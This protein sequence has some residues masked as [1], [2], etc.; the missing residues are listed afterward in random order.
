MST[1][2][3]TTTDETPRAR[4]GRTSGKNRTRAGSGTRDNSVRRRTMTDAERAGEAPVEIGK[5]TEVVE[6]TPEPDAAA[7]TGKDAPTPDPSPQA[8]KDAAKNTGDAA[9]AKTRPVSRRQAAIDAAA[10]RRKERGEGEPKSAAKKPGIKATK[11]PAWMP[12]AVKRSR[13]LS[14]G[15]PDP[16]TG[17]PC[18]DMTLA[19]PGPKQH[20]AIRARVLELAATDASGPM[21]ADV[22]TPDD[23]LR[24]AGGY[25]LAKLT[26]VADWSGDREDMV[27]LRKLSAEFKD[28]GWA[29]GRYLAAAL[30][31]WVE[32]RKAEIKAAKSA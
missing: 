2:T 10:A 7:D 15:R 22:I 18:G 11:Y 16:K 21:A 6:P 29:V 19:Y 28:D 9:P 23:I 1:I 3:T 27:A 26:R 4:G 14:G 24:V 5:A 17:K 30:V 25:S 32:E 8:G 13:I 20:L 12:T 31:A